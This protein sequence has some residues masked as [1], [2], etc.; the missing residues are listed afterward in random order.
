MKHVNM[1]WKVTAGKQSAYTGLRHEAEA[2]AELEEEE[3]EF[4]STWDEAE[5]PSGARAR[6]CLREAGAFFPSRVSP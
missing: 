5:E 4:G 2:A 1:R 3:E 6:S